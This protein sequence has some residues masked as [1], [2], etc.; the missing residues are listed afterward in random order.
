M[1]LTHLKCLPSLDWPVGWSSSPPKGRGGY[2]ITVAL[3]DH[4]TIV[5]EAHFSP[6]AQVCLSEIDFVNETMTCHHYLR[7]T[8]VPISFSALF[9]ENAIV[10]GKR[11]T[12]HGHRH[13]GARHQPYQES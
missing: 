6:V 7:W 11:G 10:G 13:Q 1:K 8:N 2:A 5:T 9:I 12:E 4:P 3:N